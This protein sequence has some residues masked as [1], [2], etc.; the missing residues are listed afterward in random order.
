MRYLQLLAHSFPTIPRVTTE[1]INL[2]A[3]LHLP[4][5]TEHFMA[6]LHGEDEAFHHVLRNASGNIKRKVNE[7]FDNTLRESAKKDL[8][9]LIYYPEERLEIARREEI[10]LDDYYQTVLNQLITVC[11]NVSSKYT[12]SKVRKC[13]P[14]EYSYIIEELLHESSEDHNKQAYFNVI[15]KT[16]I[17]THRA[18]HFIICLSYLI[19]RLAIDRLHILGDIYDRG[20]GAHLI[21]DTLCDYHHLD[22]QWGNH[23]ILWMGA[24]AGNLCCV[25]GVLRLSLRYANTRTLEE[26][27]GINMVPLATFAMETYGNDP[28]T[29][30]LPHTEASMQGDDEK[31]R[32]LISQMHKAIAIL[33]FKLEGQL[34]HQHPEWQMDD[35]ALLEHLHLDKGTITIDG[36]DYPLLD[37]NFPTIDPNDPYALTPAENDLIHRLQHSFVINERLKRHVDMLLHRGG[38]YGIYNSNLLFHA[39]VPMTEDG[40]LREVNVAGQRCKGRELLDCVERQ[41]RMAFDNEENKQSR[42]AACDYFWY[43]WCGPDSP[44]FDKSKMATFERYFI[45]D[46][47]VHTEKRGAYY[48]LREGAAVCDLLLDEFGVSGPHRHIINGHVPVRVGKGENPIKADGRLMVIDGGFARAYHD[49]TGIA[50]YTLVFHSRGFQLVQHEPF[51][52]TEEAILNGTDIRSTTQIVELTGHRMMV[53][54]TDIGRD[55]ATQISDLKK[56]LKAYRKGIIKEKN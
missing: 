25:A 50:G 20:P 52:S 45:A 12:R 49:T 23:D 32:R 29:L 42:Q 28:C 24:A 35:R 19:Q 17:D 38:M 2:E 30:F 53:A 5:P 6:D 47:S 48:L 55:I 4:K 46:K 3:I 43:L 8:C 26:G 14:S 16:I 18:D 1:I 34:Y 37:T 10:D 9:T 31:E 21:M 7:L 39:S 56:L 54:D 22:I 41:V 27:Y 40:Q 51:S 44:L 15:I 13:L 11:R 33:Q 36:T